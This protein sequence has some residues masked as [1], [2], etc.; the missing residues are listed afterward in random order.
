VGAL[1][2][3]ACTST[4][5]LGRATVTLSLTVVVGDRISV[6]ALGS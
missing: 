2:V 5:T 4:Q 6:I 3:D 1:A